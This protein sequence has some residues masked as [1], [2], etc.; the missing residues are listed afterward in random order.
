MSGNDLERE[1]IRMGDVRCPKQG[2]AE[3]LLRR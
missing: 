2:A 1:V 3:L